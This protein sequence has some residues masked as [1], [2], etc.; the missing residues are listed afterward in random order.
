MAADA[1]PPQDTAPATDTG[2]QEQAAPQGMDALMS[3]MDELSQQVQSIAPPAQADEPAWTGGI[4][5]LPYQDFSQPQEQQFDQQGQQYQDPYGQQYQPG[6]YAPEYGADPQAQ[7]QQVMQQLNEYVSNAVQQQIT[8]FIQAQ[9]ANELERK[10][11][12]LADNETA[13]KVVREAD[14]WAKRAGLPAEHARNPE[15]VELVYLAQQARDRASQQTAADGGQQ[16][17]HLEGSGAQPQG[18]EMDEGDQ[19]LARFGIDPSQAF[20]R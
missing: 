15:L 13:A 14:L 12:A 2:G 19:M 3:R 4:G 1:A 10:Y 20:G 18:V 6:Q 9:K 11:P 7:Q 5:D 8:P 16:D 17:V